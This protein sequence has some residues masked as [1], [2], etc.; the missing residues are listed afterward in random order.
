MEELEGVVTCSLHILIPAIQ[1]VAGF[2]K[3]RNSQSNESR[4]QNL[5]TVVALL[6]KPI[7]SDDVMQ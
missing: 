3:T 6:V 7:G 4:N 1:L 5:I 2:R